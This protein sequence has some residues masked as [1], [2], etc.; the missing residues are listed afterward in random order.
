[1]EQLD[2]VRQR[3]VGG[4]QQ[5]A[6]VS[7]V[8]SRVQLLELSVHVN[9]V[10]TVYL[11]DSDATHCFVAASLVHSAGLRTIQSDVLEVTLADGSIN[12]VRQ[13]VWLPVVLG[14]VAHLVVKCYVL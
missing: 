9:H 8:T 5:G 7:Q 4:N 3:A 1:M 13:T 2:Q 6:L 10:G 12:S 14:G 11:I